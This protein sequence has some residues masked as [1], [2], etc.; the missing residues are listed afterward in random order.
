MVKIGG[1]PTEDKWNKLIRNQVKSLIFEINQEV[2][3]IVEEMDVKSRAHN[4]RVV[5]YNF[6][7]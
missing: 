6:T 1:A 5:K 3:N 4:P 2:S 7:T